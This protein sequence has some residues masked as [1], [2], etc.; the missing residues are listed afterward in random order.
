MVPLL[1][2]LQ[3]HPEAG[4]LWST[5]I[6]DL[7][8]GKFGFRATTHERNLYRGTVDGKDVLI[9]RQVDDYAVATKDHATAEKL[10]SVINAHVTT[11]SKGTGDKTPVGLKLWCD[12]V[13]IMQS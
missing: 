12:G 3:G 10:V 11:E 2:A 5:K 7:L 8:I 1:K 4:A 13:D 9:C 6:N